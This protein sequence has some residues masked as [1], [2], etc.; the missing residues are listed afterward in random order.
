MEQL[1][2]DVQAAKLLGISPMTLR[3][4]RC[5]HTLE[6]PIIRIGKSIRYHPSQL[7]EWVTQ[8][9]TK[10]AKKR[11]ETQCAEKRRGRPTKAEQLA[12]AKV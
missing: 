3:K 9:A 10:P 7:M 1:L 5:Y 8:Q 12:K 6:I 4:D 11:V 2:N